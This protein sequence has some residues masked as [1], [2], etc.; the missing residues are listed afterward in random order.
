MDLSK[1]IPKLRKNWMLSGVALVEK[2]AY[3]S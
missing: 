1:S 3:S 2:E